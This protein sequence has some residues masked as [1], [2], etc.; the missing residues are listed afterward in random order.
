MSTDAALVV[1]SFGLVIVVTMMCH[2]A[3]R[4]DRVTSLEAQLMPRRFRFYSGASADVNHSARLTRDSETP[5]VHQLPSSLSASPLLKKTNAL[6][7]STASDPDHQ[8]TARAGLGEP[9]RRAF[10][11]SPPTLA[12]PVIRRGRLEWK[13]GLAP[14]SDCVGTGNVAGY[15]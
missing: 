3:Q 8:F 12:R 6:G 13:P 15:E 14:L 11:A 1:A 9:A 7:F 2:W 10:A 5:G 4:H